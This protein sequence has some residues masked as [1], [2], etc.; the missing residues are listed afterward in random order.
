MASTPAAESP[1]SR[2]NAPAGIEADKAWRTVTIRAQVPDETGTVYLT[3]NRPEL[4]NWNPRGFA[5]TGTGRERTAVLHLPPGTLLEYK[6][7]LG[8]WDREGVGPSG[9]VLPNHRLTVDADKDV[10]ILIPDF[11]KATAEY[12]RG[13][14]GSGVLGRLARWIDRPFLSWASTI[15]NPVPPHSGQVA[16]AST[17]APQG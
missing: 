4:G 16:V 11:K 12:L 9:T 3:G 5:M 7:T 15:L 13:W 10:T 17:V 2:T 6:F 8:S 1:T 14:R